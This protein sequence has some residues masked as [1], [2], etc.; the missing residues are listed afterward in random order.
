MFVGGF[1]LLI[2]VGTAGLL[3]LPGLTTGPELGFVDALF[4]VTSAICITGLAVVDPATAFTFWGQLYLLVCVQVGGL[5]VIT[6]T[7]S[8]IGAMGRRMSLR[9]ELLTSPGV[10]VGQRSEAGSLVLATVRMTLAIEAVGAFLLW[11]LFLGDYGPVGAIWP[12]VFHAVSAFCNAG[13]STIHGGLVAHRE[14]PGVLAV[15]AALV[16]IGGIG[17]LTL[18]EL[19]RWWR[20]RGVVRRRLSTHTAAAVGTTAVLLVVGTVLFAVFEWNGVLGDL[21]LSD[22]LANAAFMSVVPRSAG[23]HSVSYAE[24][25]NRAGFLTILLMLVGGSPGSTAGGIK[26]TALAVLGALAI[27]RIRGRRH[28]ALHGRTVP[29]GTIQR[30]VSLALLAFTILSASVLILATTEGGSLTGE[31]DRERF[32]PIFFEA[33]S[34]FATTGLSMDYTPTLSAAGKLWTSLMMF[35]GRVGPLPFFAAIAIRGRPSVRETRA[36]HEDL[37]VG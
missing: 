3:L 7:T 29:D 22:K 24:I 37:I 27:S 34:A 18:E 16:V 20:G 35:V 12:A 36:A 11:L 31:D 25:G 30:T 21:D 2:L 13:F 6:L 9:T 17:F 5:G 28:V 19:L 32:L 33:A 26:T 14:E 15:I 1:A 8:I 10:E 23:F 4:M